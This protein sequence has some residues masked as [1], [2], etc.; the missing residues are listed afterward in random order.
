MN[1][2]EFLASLAKLDIRLWLEGDNLRFSAP[3][4][5][6]TPAIR[7][8]V[9][10]RKPEIIEF[11]RQARK[12]NEAPISAIARDQSIPVSFAQQRLWLLDQ[13]NPRDVTYNISSALRIR[14]ALKL[15]VLEKVFATLVQRH[16]TLRTRFANLDGEPF[17][18]ID[19]FERW[20]LPLIDLG[21]LKDEALQQR[22]LTEV[23][24][25]TLTPYDLAQGPL[26]R[27]RL[28]RLADDHH[29]LIAGMHH[30]ISDAW[31]MDVLVKEIG[32]LYMAFSVGMASPLPPLPIQYADF[33]VWQRQQMAADEMAKHQQY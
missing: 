2:V 23:H 25:E 31:S 19:P 21:D 29:V 12:L 27:A 24:A 26:F 16:E 13:I 11:L 8:Q 17:Q 32:M 15:A 28:L 10:T 5:A 18:V 4:G 33:S 9:V 1:V 22:V 20:T 6:F 7:E 3:E 30:I 14:G